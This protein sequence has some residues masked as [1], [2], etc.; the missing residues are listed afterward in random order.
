V[1]LQGLPVLLMA[2]ALA[3]GLLAVLMLV[4]RFGFSATRADPSRLPLVLRPS[5]PLPYAVSIAAGACFW[6]WR[7]SAL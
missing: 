7:A 5:A 3:G 1:G 4:L 2:I 6:A